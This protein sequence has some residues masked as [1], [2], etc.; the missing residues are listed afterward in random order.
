MAM[1]GRT[2]PK[3]KKPQ[4]AL[5]EESLRDAGRST[6]RDY[7]NWRLIQVRVARISRAEDIELTE[8]QQALVKAWEKSPE[9][10]PPIVVRSVGGDSYRIVD[11]YHRHDAAK[12]AGLDYIWAIEVI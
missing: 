9:T 11:G 10:I 8:E 2:R 5:I 1:A 4:E 6:A 7:F 12:R 3:Y